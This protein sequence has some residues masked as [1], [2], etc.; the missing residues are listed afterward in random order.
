MVGGDNS[1]FRPHL[2]PSSGKC[3]VTLYSEVEPMTSYVERED[4]FYYR[5]IY[6]A[7]AKLLSEDRG[8]MRIGSDFQCEIQPLLGKGEE[9]PRFKENWEELQWDPRNVP[10]ASEVDSFITA[11]KGVG[12]YGRACDPASSQQNPYL[13]NAAAAAS[14]DI[15]LQFAHDIFF[16][17]G[18]DVKKAMSL[19]L[20]STPISANCLP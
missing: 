9:D 11:A 3:T 10:S 20:P 8:S 15:T 13:I 7:N 5:L 17:A 16:K 19:L 6:D 14:R 18:F 12:L 2:I 4:A 1:P